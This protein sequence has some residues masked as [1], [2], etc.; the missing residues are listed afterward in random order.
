[1]IAE[2]KEREFYMYLGSYY[3]LEPPTGAAHGFGRFLHVIVYTKPIIKS[4]SSDC[5]V[6]VAEWSGRDRSKSAEEKIE[7]PGEGI[8]I[9]GTY[10][11]DSGIMDLSERFT[12]WI[13][14][15]ATETVQWVFFSGSFPHLWSET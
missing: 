10:P 11:P 2:G 9:R 15:A 3:I 8:L 1:M 14:L 12:R 7:K 6:L 13:F 4:N 5:D